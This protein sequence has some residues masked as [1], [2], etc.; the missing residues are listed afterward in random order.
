MVNIQQKRIVRLRFEFSSNFEGIK[1]NYEIIFF[2]V[3]NVCLAH[4]FTET[5]D[6]GK[7]RCCALIERCCFTF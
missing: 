6:G 5:L 1:N 2:L 4:R 7:M 3:C